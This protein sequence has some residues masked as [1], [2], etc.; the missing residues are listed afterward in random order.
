MSTASLLFAVEDRE[1]ALEDVLKVFKSLSISLCRIESRPSKSFKWKYDIIVDFNVTDGSRLKELEAALKERESSFQFIESSA[2]QNHGN[3]KK[4]FIKI[5]F[6]PFILELKI[7]MTPWFPKC[8]S[9]MDA[10]AERVLDCGE[11]LSADHPGFTDQVYR[12]RRAEITEIA[13]Q[14]KT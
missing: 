12:A 3:G 14:F 2:I 5:Q 9:D 13:K 11:D 1:G 7:K 8:L 6:I 10:F 4:D